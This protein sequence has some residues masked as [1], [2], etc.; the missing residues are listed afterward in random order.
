MNKKTVKI[1]TG[2][3]IIAIFGILLLVNR[4]TGMMFEEMFMYFFPIPMIAFSAQY[5]WKSSVPVLIS[6]AFFAFFFGTFTTIFYAVSEALIGLVFG[7][8]IYR[9]VD[10]TK[11]LLVVMGLSAAVNL[12]NTV[13]LA[14]L[15]GMNLS[16]EVAE[17]QRMLDSVISQS[18]MTLPDGILS[19]DYVMQMLVISMIVLGLAQGFVIYELSL[20][21]LRRLR[22]QFPKPKSIYSLFPPKWTGIAGIIAYYLYAYTMQNPLA[23]DV[24]QAIVQSV[25]MFADL[26]L[27][28][29][30]FIGMALFM[31][32]RTSL[33]NI[34][35]IVICAMIFFVM[36]LLVMVAGVVY[37]VSD[38]HRMAVEGMQARAY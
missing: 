6:M 20:L 14:E 19:D 22:F 18:G 27:V 15:F 13:V 32:E 2:A 16:Q 33:P 17:I 5:G 34:L 4:Q 37:I 7:D 38:Y 12:L 36:P 25:G 10:M 29:F 24:L 11:T 3:V 23:N 30:G 28:T 35:K 1:T 8:M 9:K 21:I 26:Y 31:K